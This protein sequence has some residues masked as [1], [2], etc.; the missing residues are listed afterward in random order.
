MAT[1]KIV[2]PNRGVRN[3][4]IIMGAVVWLTGLL[5]VFWSGSLAENLLMYSVFLLVVISMMIFTRISY[6]KVILD[7]EGVTVTFFRKKSYLWKDIIEAGR[8]HSD[9]K[10][11]AARYFNLVLILPGGS[12]KRPGKDRGYLFRKPFQTVSLPNERHI[13]DFIR[14]RYGQLDFDD[15]DQVSAF[16]KKIHHLEQTE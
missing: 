13:L 3:V 10:S 14:A 1:D 6:P 16:D 8:Y 15:Y 5:P 2:D 9:R 7:Y 4:L 12:P 11:P